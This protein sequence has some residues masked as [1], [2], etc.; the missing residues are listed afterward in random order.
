MASITYDGQSFMIDG[1]RIWLVSG[2]I[3]FA[4]VPRSQWADRI[5]AAKQAGL[6]TIDV[7]VFWGR[8]EPRQAQFD[9]TGENDLRHFVQ[10][11]HQAGMMCI[12]RPGPYL[13]GGWDLG[14]LPSWLLALN[15]IQ[16]RTASAPFLEACSRYITA[17]A[18][19]VRDLQVTSSGA[20]GPIVLIQ[21]ESGWTCGDDTLAAQY[22]GELNRYFREAGL[23]VPTVNAND[24]WQG[25]EGEIDC[26]TGYDNLLANLRQLATVRPDQPRIVIDLPVGH[27]GVWG[28]PA[29][30]PRAG[31]Q[32]A[33]KLVEVLAAGGQYNIAPFHG[34]TNFGFSAGREAG[35]LDGFFTTSHGCGSPL[36]ELGA[37]GPMLSAV[38]R[39]CTFASRFSRVLA[40][41]EPSRHPVIQHPSPARNGSR[42][43]PAPTPPPVVVYTGGVHGSVAFIFG[44]ESG[45]TPAQSV[46]LLLAD[47]TPMPVHIGAE[48]AAWCLFDARLTGRTNLDYC[49]LSA[50][51]VVGRVFVCF[52]PAGTMGHMSINGSRLEVPVPGG[53]EP[54]VLTHEG[55]VVVVCSVEQ[56]DCIALDDD[57]VYI[58]VGGLSTPTAAG[59]A[60]QPLAH[61]DY[62]SY[63]RITGA[64]DTT[65]H[66]SPVA[67]PPRHTPPP[68]QP[69]APAG[70]KK[71]AAL[72]V[73]APPG[74]RL[75]LAHWMAAPAADFADGSSARFASITGPADLD[76]LG[77]PYG[78]GWYRIRM[79]TPPAGKHHVLFPAA[80]DRLHLTLD[81]EAM[82][83][84]GLGPGATG[85]GVLN[86]KKGPHTLVVLAENAGRFSGGLRLASKVGL[87]GHAWT[88]N[89]LKLGAP[90]IQT[91]EPLDPLAFM[92]PQWGVHRGDAT[93]PE[94]L[95]W[96]FSHRRKSPVFVRMRGGGAKGLL[97]LNNAPLFAFDS[98]GFDC[99]TI[100]ASLLQ[101]ST[102]VVQL[103]LLGPPG[104]TAQHAKDLGALVEF[105][106]G[107]ENLTDG[108]PI[109]A[110][111]GAAKADRKVEW[112]FA[113][114][115][116]PPA[117]AFEELGRGA[118]KPMKS[119]GW[120]KC[121][122]GPDDSHG[123]L[124]LD[125]AGMTKGQMYINGRHLGR[126]FVA[127]ADGK[128]VGPQTHYHV[129]RSWLDRA[130]CE[131]MLFDEHGAAPGKVRLIN[132]EIRPA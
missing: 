64:G 77:A 6:N 93:D 72:V 36:T 123:P 122:F 21:N 60:P 83:V 108:G 130:A 54:T 98:A 57:A 39:V 84:V 29:A 44:D 40:N 103:A 52:G 61:P 8:H 65:S 88:V 102:S 121:L 75:S 110:G 15:N 55:I 34:G 107:Q 17:L 62:K 100:D 125:L 25:V 119:P 3:P 66:K 59:A 27:C 95:T 101:K 51:A 86:F 109:P 14:G 126:Y 48:S 92:V 53:R 38:R 10:L 71:S 2:S 131:L 128:P 41:L 94:R 7:P 30:P 81:G 74:P 111:K 82:G 104:V 127:T 49:N 106:E 97:L 96:S 79:K 9:W 91:G 22:L 31:G 13:G 105:F 87:Y 23:T 1:R 120:W 18:G 19:Q 24:L 73:E 89:P 4:R 32:V 35:S 70:K 63:T 76:A 78:Y 99:V 26:W 90:K 117:D 118:I 33:R 114:W 12:L 80:A 45:Q 85:D 43:A 69:P 47:G 56:I 132:P 20:G 28:R 112:A 129:P 116:P 37:P 113:K 11:I 58:G 67:A 16:L 42:S 115:E 124:L 5:H 68:V 46:N 50:F